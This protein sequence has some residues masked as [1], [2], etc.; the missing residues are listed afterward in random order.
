MNQP[1]PKSHDPAP[2][3]THNTDPTNPNQWVTEFK[4]RPK[5]CQSRACYEPQLPIQK[6]Q[7]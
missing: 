2:W 7:P 6:G 4:P 1:C 5:Y 3:T